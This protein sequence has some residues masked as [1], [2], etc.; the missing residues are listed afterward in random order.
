[1]LPCQTLHEICNFGI[2]ALPKEKLGSFVK[3]DDRDAENAHDKD[4]STVGKPDI[5]PALDYISV[6]NEMVIQS[7]TMLLE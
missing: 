7:H 5:A 2:F 6:E 3:A 4:K 1:M